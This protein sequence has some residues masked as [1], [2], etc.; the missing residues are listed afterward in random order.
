V[1]DRSVVVTGAGGGLGRALCAEFCARDCRVAGLGRTRENLDATAALVGQLFQGF[2]C[3]VADP[4]AVR[5]TFQEVRTRVGPV[6]VLVNNAAQYPRRDFL[7]ET[8]ESFMATVAVNLGGVVACTR[9]ALSDMV[10][11][12]EGRILNVAT[13]ADLDPISAS[14]A[15]AVSKGAI[16]IFTRAL[17]ADLADRFPRIVTNDWMPGMLATPM[18]ISNGLHPAQAARWGAALALMRDPSLN[19][20]TW[21]EDHELLSPRSLKR[22]VADRLLGRHYTSRRVY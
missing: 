20:T 8:A 18:G 1:T 2:V 14:S 7:D 4:D 3:D 5:K 11:R 17:V 10:E 15:Y 19:G 16:R 13:F 9:E 22:R 21:V 6:D 12:G